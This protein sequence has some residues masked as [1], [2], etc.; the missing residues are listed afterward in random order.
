[1]ERNPYYRSGDDVAPLLLPAAMG[2]AI[3]L[4]LARALFARVLAP[5][6]MYEY[7]IAR[8]RYIDAAVEAALAEG[9][10][11]ILLF[12]PARH[13]G[14]AL[15]RSSPAGPPLRTRRARHSER[16]DR[17]IPRARPGFAR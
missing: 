13:P 8:T 2:Q 15:S 5:R 9:V 3:H 4:K 1:M 16:Q 17:P 7:V 14:A 12:G 10:D 6:G 11:Q